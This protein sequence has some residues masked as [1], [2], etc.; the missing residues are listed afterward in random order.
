MPFPTLAFVLLEKKVKVN[1]WVQ[2]IHEDD[3]KRINSNE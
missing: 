3:N 1:N 2:V